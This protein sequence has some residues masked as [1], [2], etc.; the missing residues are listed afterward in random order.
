MSKR[1]KSKFPAL[2]KRLN[3]KSRQDLLDFDYLHKLEE[4]EMEYLNKFVAETVNTSFLYDPELKRINDVLSEIINTPEV[5]EIGVKLNKLKYRLS[6]AITDD[7]RA[8]IKEK[9]KL[10]EDKRKAV[11]SKN[12]R[13]NIDIIKK[14]EVDMQTR[15]NSVLLYPKKSDHKKLFKENNDRNA[16]LYTIS[17]ITDGLS[18]LEP[19]DFERLS[20]IYDY[21][22][23]LLDNIECARL[24]EREA[25]VYATLRELANKGC[26]VSKNFIK[27]LDDKDTS[28]E[29]L[30]FLLEEIEE[31]LG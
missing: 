25:Y 27:K 8:S 30:Y 22:N 9:I 18:T 17:K 26:T 1:S 10:L 20:T 28:Y 21:E 23:N 6:E 2:E 29:K 31:F 4:S 15:R 3:L 5:T 19:E 7:S 16:D 14:L 12:R 13:D 11:K 24:E